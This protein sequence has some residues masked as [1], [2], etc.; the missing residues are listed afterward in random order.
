MGTSS[1]STTI[2]ASSSAG[3]TTTRSRAVDTLPV[4]PPKKRIHK[5]T[6]DVMLEPLLGSALRKWSAADIRDSIMV[7]GENSPWYPMG[8][9]GVVYAHKEA[10]RSRHE[11]VPFQC[12]V[13]PEVECKQ[14]LEARGEDPPPDDGNDDYLC[15]QCRDKS[16]ED[17]HIMRRELVLRGVKFVLKYG[18][19]GR[20]TPTV[21][22]LSGAAQEAAKLRK[23][24]SA[25]DLAK[26]K[27]SLT[28]KT[29]ELGELLAM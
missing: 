17:R 14:C 13:C 5:G 19:Q 15:L 6:E 16:D 23:M 8:M 1:A 10:C 4:S 25:S 28:V 9:N 11:A 27:K 2:T 7:E 26:F 12:R 24:I 20:S 18:C 22:P 3:S 21:I 29:E